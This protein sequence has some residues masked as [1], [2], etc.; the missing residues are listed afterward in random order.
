MID[1]SVQRLLE[2]AIDS[3]IKLQLCLMFYENRRMEG[4]AAQFADRIYRDIWST[5]EALREMAEDGVLN[6]TPLAGEPIY[7]YRPRPDL[8]DPIFRLAQAYNEPLERDAIQRALREIA[9]YAPFR[10]A[11]RSNGGL[12]WQTIQAP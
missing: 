2:Q 3:P 6:A 5:R 7:R 8:V 1:S 4:T 9:S 12:E 10:R 11:A